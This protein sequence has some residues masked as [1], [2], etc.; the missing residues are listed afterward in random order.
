MTSHGRTADTAAKLAFSL[1]PRRVRQPGDAEAPDVRVLDN[2]RL[3]CCDGEQR[4]DAGDARQHR[5]A[6]GPRR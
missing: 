6:S 5:D 3:A 1:V 2:G 4:Q